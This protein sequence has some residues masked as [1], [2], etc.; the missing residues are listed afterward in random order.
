VILL[1]EWNI[2]PKYRRDV[3]KAWKE[4]KQHKDVKTVFPIHNCVG[5]NRG[6]AIVESDSTEAVQETLGFFIDYVN[7]VVTPLIR[8]K[9]PK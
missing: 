1:I 6:V 7:F 2:K 3:M 9:P 5:S 4:Y 8:F